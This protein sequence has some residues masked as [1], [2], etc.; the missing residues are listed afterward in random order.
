MG[1][2]MAGARLKKRAMGASR[3]G[4]KTSSAVMPAGMDM[5]MKKGGSV[6]KSFAM[7][8]AVSDVDMAA[9]I[10]GARAAL[11]APDVM[12]T[13]PVFNNRGRG[14]SPPQG[15]TMGRKKVGKPMPVA[16]KKGGKV[17]KKFAIGG[18][19]LTGSRMRPA[20]AKTPLPTNQYSSTTREYTP[21]QNQQRAV[22]RYQDRVANEAARQKANDAR[23]A[24]AAKQGAIREKANM[25][26]RGMNKPGT[27]ANALKLAGKLTE[28]RVTTPSLGTT[29]KL[30][31][32]GMVNKKGMKKGGMAVMIVLG[33]KKGKK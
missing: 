30:K 11:G 28:T 8:G 10:K 12:P 18:E 24:F 29:K 15:G 17:E 5:P 7:G 9:R 16:M 31:K 4:K 3:Q 32:G 19:V 2:E 22:A 21:A 13:S 20:T 1:K 25:A 23:Q 27:A 26:E 6:K 14:G 33:G